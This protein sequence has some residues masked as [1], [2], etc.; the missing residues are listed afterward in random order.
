[1]KAV[2]YYEHGGPE[3]LMYEE[4]PEP[5][6]KEGEALIRVEAC[7]LNRLDI[8]TRR[9]VIKTTAPLPHILGCDIVGYVEKQ[10]GE[11]LP[12]GSPVL[13]NPYITC[14]RCVHC[15]SGY[16]NRCIALK[17]IGFHT[18]GGYAEYVSAPINNLIPLNPKIPLEEYA[19]I[20]IDYT[21]VWH[22]LVSRGGLKVGE[23][24]LIWAG[25]SGAG[26]VATRLAKIVGAT[27]FTTVGSEEKAKKAKAFADYVFNHY[28]D[29]VP[30]LVREATGGRGVDVVLDYVGSA[31]WKRSLKCLAVGGRMITFGG[32]S[33]YTGEIDIREFYTRHLTLIGT[34]GGTKI[35]LLKALTFAEKG[36][37]RP[38]IDS[39]YPLKE[40]QSAHRKMEENKHFGKILLKP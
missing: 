36:L 24:I 40:A 34:F 29:D 39:I 21:T 5:I 15:L 23:S 28:T 4:R 6:V 38:V 18:D 31:T 16:E 27:V 37:L 14:G 13:V 11:G 35:D 12:V 3:K 2:V 33:G 32:L 10:R 25:G 7:G 20:P 19:A 1:M 22:A 8:L 30:S 26:T 9:G 17:L